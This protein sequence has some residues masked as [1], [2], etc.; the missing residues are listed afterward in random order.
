MKTLVTGGGGFLGSAV[1][2]LLVARGDS[3]RV[4][5][6]GDYPHLREIGVDVRRGDLAD[7]GA[8]ADA[9]EGCEIVFHVAANAGFWGPYESF[10]RPNV[11][12]TRN[13]IDACR[14]H[15]IRRLVF[16][17]SPSVTFAGVDQEGVDETAPYPDRFLAHY[18][19]TKAEAEK[20]VLA[21]NGP[22]LAT[23]A[24][25]P[26]LIWGP[27][28][29]H[30]APRIVSQARA[31]KLRLIGRRPNRI[32]TVYIDNAAEAHLLAADR[33]SWHGHPA[34]DPRAERPCHR[35]VAGKAYFISNGEPMPVAEIVNR[36]LDAAG[37]APVTRRV[38]EGVAYAAAALLEGAYS[39][40]RLRGEPRLTRFVARQL[41]TAHWFDIGAARRDLGYEPRV[42]IDEGMRRLAQW[43][44]DGAGE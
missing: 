8:V 18:P 2:R 32:D 6:R 9:A 1:V 13:A 14:R 40:L 27:G 24:L 34:H 7:A 23:V 44:R 12:G 21:A 41:A 10:Y 20:L 31:G 3:V 35:P 26:H 30:L 36:I 37:L 42:S 16:T 5:S 33:L 22:E 43:F 19:R 25:R 17:S 4:F 38:P 28:D 39:V 11:L 15:S 29:P